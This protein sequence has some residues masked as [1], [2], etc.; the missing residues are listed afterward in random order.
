MN[1]LTTILCLANS[2]KFSGHCIAGKAISNGII[3]SWIRPVSKRRGG[4]LSDS[5]CLYQNG[6]RPELLDV[7]SVPLKKSAHDYYQT[8]NYVIDENG[9]WQFLKKALW[10][11][12]VAA[13]DSVSGELWVNGSDSSHGKND[14]VPEPVAK[15]LNRSLYLIRPYGLSIQAATEG[16]MRKI[17][18]N[19]TLNTIPYKFI[20][21]DPIIEKR[22][23]EQRD[24]SY[25]VKDALLC[26]SL[27]ELFHGYA[28]KLVAAVLTPDMGA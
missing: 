6:K 7:M 21:T 11:S 2:R 26:V 8:E 20:I 17:R 25:P 4:E 15:K 1:P 5:E 23:L 19:F 14:R 13:L 22:L 12:A 10:S 28:Y 3:G 27:G 18:A 9:K 24:G 16:G